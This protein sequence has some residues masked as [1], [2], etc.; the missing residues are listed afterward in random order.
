MTMSGDLCS[1]QLDTGRSKESVGRVGS[2]VRGTERNSR[3]LIMV[4]ILETV[5]GHLKNYSTCAA[6]RDPWDG[7]VSITL[8]AS[9]IAAHI[10]ISYIL[11]SSQPY[12]SCLHTQE[13]KN[14]HTPVRLTNFLRHKG[15]KKAM[16]VWEREQSIQP[17]GTTSQVTWIQL[18]LSTHA[19]QDLEKKT[20]GFLLLLAQAPRSGK[21]TQLDSRVPLLAS[22]SSPRDPAGSGASR[23][24]PRVSCEEK[25][26]RRK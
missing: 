14:P 6:C 12:R 3:Y 21:E 19:F 9:G 8:S 18:N 13:S 4:L 2:E 16:V 22:A 7:T 10:S 15:T 26:R 20:M 17:A 25:V 11:G 23:D 5:S 1:E 24:V